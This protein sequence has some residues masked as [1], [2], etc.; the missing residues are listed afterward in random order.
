M[1]NATREQSK[2]GAEIPFPA[3]EQ[4]PASGYMW[5][6]IFIDP[7]IYFLSHFLVIFLLLSHK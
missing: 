3:R 1:P 7:Q 2:L 5:A 4:E 6:C